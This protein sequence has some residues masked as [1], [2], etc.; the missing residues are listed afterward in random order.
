MILAVMT[1]A[2][3][4]AAPQAG[5]WTNLFDGTSLKGWNVVGDAN[6]TVSDGVL[7]ADR[8]AGFLVTPEIFRSRWSSG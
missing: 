7:Q 2:G 6:W 8:G 3:V 5:P 1:V 4:A